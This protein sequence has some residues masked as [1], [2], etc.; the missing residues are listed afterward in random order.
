MRILVWSD[1]P[2]PT[3]FGRITKE[4]ARRLVWRGHQVVAVSLMYQGGPTGEPY[5][6]WSAAPPRD[7]WAV[8]YDVISNFRPEVI[9]AAQDFPYLH[10]LYWNCKLDWSTMAMVGITPI[11]GTPI[12]PDWLQLVDCL[13]GMMVIS[14]FGVEAMRQAGKRVVLCHPGV[15]P[16]E[17]H[18]ATWQEKIELRKRA[19]IPENAFIVGMFCVNQ[20]RKNIPGTL[21]GFAEFCKD[22]PEALLYLDM[23]KESGAGWSIPKT[24]Q[25][26]EF[27][28]KRVLFRET[29]AKALPSL[30]DRYCILDIQSLMSFR[31][32]FGLPILEAMACGIP[33]IAMD[34]C[35]GTEL[36]SD[37]RGFLVPAIKDSLGQTY[38]PRG[39]WGG[40]RDMHPDPPTYINILNTAYSNPGLRQ[41]MAETGYA[42]AKEQTWDKAADAVEEVLRQAVLKKKALPPP[43]PA[44]IPADVVIKQSVPLA[45]SAMPDVKTLLD[46]RSPGADAP[47][48]VTMTIPA[49][50]IAMY[51]REQGTVG[52]KEGAG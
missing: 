35:S 20:G 25:Q 30:R 29:V 28:P 16:N 51:L 26:M 46:T 18:P 6:V 12:A 10:T 21:D 45:V 19:G 9:L 48:N 33:N 27:D 36:L 50:D 14:K 3:G 49:A 15:D 37:G 44:K 47:T 2:I 39:T 41:R 40:A 23:D 31:E 34:W 4:S 22:K 52:Q 24:I 7:L 17:F 13:D 32:G 1:L 42:F 5:D 43:P 38:M 8:S 11:D